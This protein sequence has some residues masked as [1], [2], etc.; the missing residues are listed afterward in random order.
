MGS[1][2]TQLNNTLGTGSL[3]NSAASVA[4]SNKALIDSGLQGSSSTTTQTDA[5][6]L[7]GTTT[8]FL[9]ILLAQ[10]KYQDPTQPMKGTEFIDSIARLSDVE[11]N[12]NVNTNLNNIAD[13]LKANNSQL[14]SAVSYIN[15]KIDF[16][17]SQVALTSG[18][19][20]FTYTLP[21]AG[22]PENVTVVI[23]N[24]KGETVLTKPGSTNAGDNAFSW[25]GKDDSGNKLADGVYNVAVTYPDPKTANNAKPTSLYA[26]TYTTGVV[27]GADFTGST[28]VLDIGNIAIPLSDVRKLYGSGGAV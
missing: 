23:K 3:A 15:K 20:A 8:Q 17:S 11:Q 10:L 2:T 7:L 22:T 9:N 18:A 25:D 6:K 27:T 4:A 21:T 24:A 19:G 5:N 13:I 28:S 12:I 16:N 26:P 14:G 1:L